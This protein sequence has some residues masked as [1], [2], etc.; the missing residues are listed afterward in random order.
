[1]LP[2]AHEFHLSCFKGWESVLAS[3]KQGRPACPLCKAELVPP[4]KADGSRHTGAT[5]AV[6]EMTELRRPAAVA[7]LPISGA[8][9]LLFLPL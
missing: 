4:P 8:G 6:I 2:C 7:P 3:S 9:A 1:M 5:Q